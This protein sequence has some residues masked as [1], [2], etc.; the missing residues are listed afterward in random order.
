MHCDCCDK[1]LDEAE[2]S[3]RFV[4]SGNFVNMC[5]E[6]RSYLPR[7]LKWKTRSDMERKE[8]EADEAGEDQFDLRDYDEEQDDWR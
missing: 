7:N 4:E 6:C 1:L 5:T 2:A 3:A 8:R